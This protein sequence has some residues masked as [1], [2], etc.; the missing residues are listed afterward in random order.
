[1]Y[2]TKMELAAYLN[3]S[4][5]SV[6]RQRKEGRIPYYRLGGQIRFVYGEVDAALAKN[7][8]I[9]RR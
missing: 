9:S 7:C 3:L 4:V 8:R 2:H 6:D 5:S 1:M